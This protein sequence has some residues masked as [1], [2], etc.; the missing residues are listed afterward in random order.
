MSPSHS[1][2]TPTSGRA[3]FI[4]AVSA[5]VNA[6][7]VTSFNRPVAAPMT[8]ASATSPSQT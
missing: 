5:I 2:I 6:P 4:T 1:A 8:A 3:I 7:S